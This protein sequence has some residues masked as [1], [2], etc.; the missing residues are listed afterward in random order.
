M[1]Q[2]EEQLGMKI[3]HVILSG[4]SAGGHLAVSVTLLAILR[5]FRKPDALLVHY[6]VWSMDITRFFPSSLLTV[7]E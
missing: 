5:G 1:T 2:A 7:D 4:D 6:P 3:R